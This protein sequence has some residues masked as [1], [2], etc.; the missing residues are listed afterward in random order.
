MSVPK[1]VDTCSACKG[2]VVEETTSEYDPASGPRIIGPGYK[3]QC[4]KV[5][6]YYCADC[7]LVYRLP[8]ARMKK[9]RKAQALE[10][11]PADLPTD[12]L[13]KLEIGPFARRRKRS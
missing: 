12:V 5:T 8:P 6:S 3:K 1:V 9:L 13:K 4:R 2:H 10:V 7:G 11:S